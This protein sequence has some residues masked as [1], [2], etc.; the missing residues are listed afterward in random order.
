MTLTLRTHTV[1]WSLRRSFHSGGITILRH[2]TLEQAS[3][4]LDAGRAGG[5]G[6]HGRP[7]GDAGPAVRSARPLAEWGQQ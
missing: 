7:V 2:F 5:Q 3:Q 6:G 1:L 4:R